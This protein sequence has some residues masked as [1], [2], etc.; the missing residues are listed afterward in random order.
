MKQE[1]EIREKITTAYTVF[2]VIAKASICY[3]VDKIVTNNIGPKLPGKMKTLEFLCT[4]LGGLYIGTVISDYI[5]THGLKTPEEFK[6]WYD[7]NVIVTIKN[8]EEQEEQPEQ[9]ETENA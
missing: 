5:C 3:T 7:E 6:K 1:E 9:E 2:Y 8:M 4:Q